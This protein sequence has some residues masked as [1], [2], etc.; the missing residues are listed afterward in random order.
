VAV[1]A[2]LHVAGEIKMN[3]R[4]IQLGALNYKNSLTFT[5]VQR[6]LLSQHTRGQKKMSHA[7]KNLIN[8][9]A[10]SQHPPFAFQEHFCKPKTTHT[11]HMAIDPNEPPLEGDEDGVPDLNEL[12]AP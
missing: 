10:A 2:I 9:L 11:S 12:F 5:C 4:Q 8:I 6:I 3:W 7:S 1:A